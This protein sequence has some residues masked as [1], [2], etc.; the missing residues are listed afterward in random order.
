[1]QLIGR[2]WKVG[3]VIP[4]FGKNLKGGA[5][6]QA[7]QIATRLKKI[8]CQ[9]TVLS[10]C[11][12]S[13]LHKWHQNYYRPGVSKEG[14]IDTIRFPVAKRNGEAFNQVVSKLLSTPKAELKP[15]ICPITNREE[16]I[17]WQE[18]I[19]SPDLISYLKSE[20]DSYDFFIFLPYLF[21]TSIE[22]INAVPDKALLQACLHDECYAY[23]NR[24]MD[25]VYKCKALLFN[26]SGEYQLAKNI[27]GSWIEE[28]S[29]VIGE[30]VEYQNNTAGYSPKISI[31]RH[32]ILCLGRK[33]Q[34]KN[35]PLLVES[36]VRYCKEKPKSQLSLILA[37]PE[38]VAIPKDN[39]RIID[40]GL[41]EQEF[42]S[43]LLANSRA[44]INPS[45]NESFS[46]VIFESWKEGRPIV[47]HKD[48]L[49][50]Y[51]A[52]KDS[53]FAGWSVA[54]PEDFDTVLE[55][56]DHSSDEEIEQL[57][58]KGLSYAR[59]MSDWDEVMK[60]YIYCFYSLPDRKMK[61]SQYGS[62]KILIVSPQQSLTEQEKLDLDEF[63]KLCSQDLWQ[64]ELLTKDKGILDKYKDNKQ[65]KSFQSATSETDPALVVWY[66]DETW[67][68][69][70]NLIK[71]LKCKKIRKS[72]AHKTL[73]EIDIRSGTLQDL[74]QEESL[75]WP[76][77]QLF[78][79]KLLQADD[80]DL[81]EFENYNKLGVNILL[82]ANV[83]HPSL[84]MIARILQSFSRKHQVQ[85]QVLIPEVLGKAEATK[86][87]KS[88]EIKWSIFPC[89]EGPTIPGHI[90][91]VCDILLS[92][93]SAQLPAWFALQAC[94]YHLPSL[95]LSSETKTEDGFFTM[96]LSVDNIDKIMAFIKLA[97]QNS[98]FRDEL[99]DINE[100]LLK[101]HIPGR[102]HSM[103]KNALS[104]YSVKG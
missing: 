72:S 47:V 25:G 64:I 88:K 21:P 52:L 99:N 59:K 33:C 28:K 97:S 62:T 43:F 103:I 17:Y 93:E 98:K 23:L 63:L 71:D 16:Q 35:T 7:W 87:L 58:I 4:W 67:V 45:V 75:K 55:K 70:L 42:K 2:E 9:V 1:M 56:I 10:T 32:Y 101:S 57:G 69:G 44:L 15:G 3:I 54:S 78:P 60:R 73:V 38:V 74:Q 8:G 30:G 48:C 27:Y 66:G 34:E 53:D 14:D 86:N 40:L 96:A 50:T 36:F 6:Q 46:R 91:R 85:V 49:A 102:K 41:V 79:T 51:Q 24:T 95:K 29:Y 37:G 39:P 77:P 81:R 5:E 11:S 12:R 18:N 61:K 76:C 92:F 31:P 83:N 89:T 20:Q 26:S 90:Y 80:Y 13:F 84:P 94:A 82:L 19:N 65:V 22:G 104:H 100:S 68:D